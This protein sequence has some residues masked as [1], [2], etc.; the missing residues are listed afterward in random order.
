[1]AIFAAASEAFSK[2]NINCSVTESLKRFA[3]VTAAAKEAQVLVRG[4]VSCAAGCPYQVP[5]PRP[6]E[7]RLD[8]WTFGFKFGGFYETCALIPIVYGRSANN[9]WALI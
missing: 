7:L 8:C 4:Y 3:D 5:A 6:A 2:A 9:V 1:V